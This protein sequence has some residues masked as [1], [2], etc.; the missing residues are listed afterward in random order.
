MTEGRG[1][2]LNQQGKENNGRDSSKETE[3]KVSAVAKAKAKAKRSAPARKRKKREEPLEPSHNQPLLDRWTRLLTEKIGDGVVE[4]AYINRPDHHRPTIAVSNTK[5]PEVSRLLLEEESLAF[6]YLEN[7]S[8]V[9][10]EEHME[11]LYHF[12]SLK[13]GHTLCIKVKTDREDPRIPSVTD[14]WPAANWHEREVYDLLGI[15]FQGHPELKRILMP[16]DWVGHPLRKDYKPYDQG[17]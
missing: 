5:W 16:E 10:Y 14:V 11:V 4:E 2:D 6:E 13:H 1:G 9:D 8:G 17:L 7:L 3:E 12:V 15:R